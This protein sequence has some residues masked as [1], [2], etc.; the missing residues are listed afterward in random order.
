MRIQ[1]KNYETDGWDKKLS[2][3]RRNGVTEIYVAIRR[4][5]DQALQVV[6]FFHCV[7]LPPVGSV[8][9]IVLWRVQ[10]AVHA[11]DLEKVF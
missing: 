4:E 9:T 7:G 11:P 5:V 8:L 6:C 3:T 1:N 10:I 2:L